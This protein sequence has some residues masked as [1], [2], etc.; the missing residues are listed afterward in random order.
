MV[1][2]PVEL[3]FV[4]PAEVV[5]WRPIVHWVLAIPHLLIANVLGKIA[6]VL[7]VVSLFRILFTGKLSVSIALK[8]LN[9]PEP[10]GRQP[11]SYLFTGSW[12][13]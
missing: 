5:N 8:L 13:T 7:A 9:L 3:H 11:L 10:V 4:A 1:S 6:D 12:R 2:Y